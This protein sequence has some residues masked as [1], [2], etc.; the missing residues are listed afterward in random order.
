MQ[1][2]DV[3]MGSPHVFCKI[4]LYNKIVMIL[5][6]IMQT[7]CAGRALHALTLGSTTSNPATIA[8]VVN[9]RH[10]N[11]NVY[12][13]HFLKLVFFSMLDVGMLL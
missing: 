4:S 7:Q 1:F 12:F 3:Q 8:S 11:E 13:K 5:Y 10:L 6:K 9:C 2:C